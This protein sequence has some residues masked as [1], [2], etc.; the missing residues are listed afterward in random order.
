M[1]AQQIAFPGAE[2]YG[3]WTVGGRGGRI[4]TVTNLNDSGEGSFRDAVEQTGARIVIFAVDGNIELKSPLCVNND[5][6]TIAGQSAPGDGICLK[7]YPLVVNASNV[8]IRYIRVRVGDRYRL[9]SDGVGGG[10]YGQKNVILDHLSVSWSIDE[11][12]SIYK[13]ENLT[14]QWCLVT[15]SLNTSVHTKGSHGFGGIWGGYKATFHH[16]LLANHASRNPRFS[17]VDG[18][19]W[20]DY[21]NNVVYNW[22]FKT[23]YG[24]GHH[25]E[26]N[27]VNNYYKPG[28][29]SLHHRLL[30]VAEDGTGRYYVAGN[31]M[32]GD[33]AVTRDNHSAVTDCVGECTSCLVDFP[34][35]SEPIHEDTPAVAYQRILESVGC[36]F[37]QDSYDREVL[38]QVREGIGTFGINGIINSQ[39]DVGGWPVL[40]AEKALIDSDGDG[41]P[42]VWESKHGLNPKSASDA[43]AYTLD[44]NYTNIEIYLNSLADK[45]NNY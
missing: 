45:C 23:A 28:P 17:S 20:V 1:Q 11:C 27:I 12:L 39:E 31:M 35:P 32:A 43:S 13:T 19:K 6:I 36:S 29:A 40:N 2:G 4:L 38:R 16:N 18:T 5:S 34:F 25:A 22:G 14:V 8:I 37:S 10:R 24:G 41:M 7:D 42:D 30:D 44:E 15:H 33:D 26:I 9:D 21:R 3:K